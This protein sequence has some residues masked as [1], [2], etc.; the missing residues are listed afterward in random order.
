VSSDPTGIL[1]AGAQAPGFDLPS[2]HSERLSLRDL[3]GKPAILVFYPGDFT[4]VCGDQLSLYNEVLPL[5]DEFDAQ[6]LAI[7]VD[8]MESHYAFAA[9]RKLAFPLL[10]DDDPLGEIARRYGVF[11]KQSQ[12][13]ERALFVVDR[14]GTIQWSY[15]SPRNVN[16]G[17]DGILTALEGLKAAAR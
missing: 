13:T 6:L 8:N 12:T 7:S 11:D 14:N 2:T 9:D 15:L 1:A 4:P 3:I 5:F 16:P 17:A 10:C